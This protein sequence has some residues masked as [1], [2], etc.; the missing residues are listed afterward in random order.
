MPRASSDVTIAALGL[1]VVHERPDLLLILLS[2]YEERLSLVLT[3]MMSLETL[4]GPIRRS[5]WAWT[6][7]FR[8]Q[9]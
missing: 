3:T 1:Q 7:L 2:T 6:T 9:S 5:S 4:A 8:A